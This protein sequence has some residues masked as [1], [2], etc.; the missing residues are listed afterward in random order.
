MVRYTTSGRAWQSPFAKKGLVFQ[1]EVASLAASS[2]PG[3]V[4][5]RWHYQFAE[6][7]TW[8]GHKVTVSHFT[9]TGTSQAGHG[10]RRYLRILTRQ[11]GM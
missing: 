3:P 1:C 5:R 9:I 6:A 7:I 2:F 11:K 4:L 8:R 10:A